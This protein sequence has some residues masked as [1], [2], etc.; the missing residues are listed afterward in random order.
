MEAR[1]A[2][3]EKGTL[4]ESFSNSHQQDTRSNIND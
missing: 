4:S 2:V 1:M 3:G